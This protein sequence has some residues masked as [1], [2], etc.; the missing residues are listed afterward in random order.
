[1]STAAAGGADRH[2]AATKPRRTRSRR[3][4][5]P[6]RK[7]QTPLKMSKAAVDLIAITD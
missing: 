6:H 7:I 2:P 4:I 1:L 5:D 3:S